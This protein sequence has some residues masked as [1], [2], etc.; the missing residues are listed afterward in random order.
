MTA[1]DE[2][3]V[4]RVAVA[5]GRALAHG[6][7]EPYLELLDP[8][9][10]FELASPAKGG[11]VGL[12]GHDEVRAYLDEMA[13]QYTELVLTPREVRELGTERFL[14]FGV[15]RG[16]VRDGTKFGTPLASIVELRDGK[17]TK[18]RGFLDEEQALAAAGEY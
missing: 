17:V 3:I 11:T 15:W 8:D 13:S 16:R 18:L 14:V 1:G 5:F 6:E 2:A 10:D 7:V 4:R 12:H 9:V